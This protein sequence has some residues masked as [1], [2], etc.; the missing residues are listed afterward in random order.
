MVNVLAPDL[1]PVQVQ[2]S[3]SFRTL[4]AV[5]IGVV[6]ALVVETLLLVILTILAWSDGVSDAAA[7][8]QALLALVASP[9][10]GLAI[11]GLTAR[12]IARTRS[13]SRVAFLAGVPLAVAVL[14][15]FFPGYFGLR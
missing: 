10:I 14:V 2:Q 15:V 5:V 12:R 3:S 7:D 4:F 1:R 13:A 6:V 8:R 9:T 11:G